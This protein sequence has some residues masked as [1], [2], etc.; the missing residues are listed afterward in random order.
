MKLDLQ[1]SFTPGIRDIDFN[2]RNAQVND[3]RHAHSLDSNGA[4]ISIVDM[5][6][7]ID[8]APTGRHKTLVT[9]RTNR[10]GFTFCPLDLHVNGS[11]RLAEYG[12]NISLKS[13]LLRRAGKPGLSKLQAVE[14]S[15]EE[16]FA[17][18]AALTQDVPCPTLLGL[19]LDQRQFLIDT[20]LQG[21]QLV[22][23]VRHKLVT[24]R[25][26][27]G[28][29]KGVR[30]DTQRR[31]DQDTF[32]ILRGE[33][34]D[35]DIRYDVLMFATL[36]GVPLN[37][38]NVAGT[39]FL[40]AEEGLGMPP[41]PE[42]ENRREQSRR[43]MQAN[44]RPLI[45]LCYRLTATNTSATPAYAFFYRP[46]FSL[47]SEKEL[48][49]TSHAGILR[50]ASQARGMMSFDGQPCT[51][52]Q[53]VLLLAPGET[54]QTEYRLL[55]EP[56]AEEA[57]QHLF[58][59]PFDE[60]LAQARAYWQAKL[61][62]AATLVLPEERITHMTRA[63]LL[64]LYTVT[65]GERRGTL[66]PCIG[67]YSPIGSESSPIIQYY[68]SMG[69]HDLAARCLQY[70]LDKQH[71]D[72]RF[73]NFG[74]YM[75]ETGAA[76]YTFGEHYRYTRDDA[77]ARRVKE[78]IVKA[79]GWIIQHHHEDAPH[80]QPGAGMIL[81]KVA[82]PED[83]FRQYMLNA[84]QYLGLSRASEML[85]NID[86]P[87]ADT[88]AAEADSFRGDIRAALAESII[89]SPVVPL[90]DGRWVPSCAPWVEASGPDAFALD[91]QLSYTH[92]A[93]YAR[94]SLLGPI[95]AV[96]AEVIAPHE[97][98]ADFLVESHY[99]HMCFDGVAFSQPYYSRHP[100][101]HL[102]RGEVRAFLRSYY[103][104]MAALADR[105]TYTFWEH[106]FGVSPHKTHEEGW[107]LMETRSMLYAESDYGPQGGTLQLLPGVPRAYLQQGQSIHVA[108]ARS[109][110]GELNFDVCSRLDDGT[111]EVDI[112]CP[113]GTARGLNS[114][115]LRIPH[116]DGCAAQ[117]IEGPGQYDAQHETVTFPWPNTNKAHLTIHF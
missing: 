64:H 90:G 13:G 52:T 28:R 46:R 62:Q 111:V 112:T 103:R 31:L 84:Y 108:H 24:A 87:L 109:Y 58:D 1:L 39:P 92:E 104:A 81:G 49:I 59:V 34:Q 43:E 114:L 65:Y 105:E 70:F 5:N 106:L 51:E 48:E 2:V 98:L 7:S 17:S 86:A 117:R 12:V 23:S 54:A 42:Q 3:V 15:A 61:D 85:R 66:A 96:F 11:I 101:V 110:Y 33:K 67:V 19:G 53:L 83:H 102:R 27:I 78:Q 41:T 45:A 55:H 57:A 29:G 50:T 4:D 38:A 91:G 47:P 32:P 77:W 71:A 80:T 94:D 99:E 10:C 26:P 97:R 95:Y 14:R 93:V 73:Q 18:A 25:I 16:S 113:Q 30:S 36:A 79:C 74:G 68:D 107:F 20:D 8:P 9:V 35:E 75:L 6:V 56:T 21:I 44:P 76:L 88:L 82:D 60:L 115:V 22:N 89:R 100:F 69:W 116:P 72:G 63:G 40:V 37:E